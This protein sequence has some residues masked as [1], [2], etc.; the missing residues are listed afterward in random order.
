MRQTL[1]TVVVLSLVGA[2]AW[3]TVPGVLAQEATPTAEAAPIT[4]ESLGSAPSPDAPGMMLVLLRAT[5]A[6]GAGLPPHVHPGQLVIAVESGT[7]GYAIVA[8]EGESGRGRIGTPTAAEVITPG[9]EVLL[10]PGEWIIEEP[11]VVHTARNAG[12]EPLVLLISGLV[13]PNEP[14]VQ[15]A[16]TGM[17]TPAA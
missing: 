12:N 14:L 8:E 7:A 3:F 5:L 10:G 4:I 17:A 9:T 1:V 2:L 15:L 6:P 16:E 13:A 11:G